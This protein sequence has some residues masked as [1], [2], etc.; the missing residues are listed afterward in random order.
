L[1][2]WIRVGSDSPS[3]DCGNDFRAAP[4]EGGEVHAHAQKDAGNRE[5]VMADTDKAEKIFAGEQILHAERFFGCAIPGYTALEGN[6][7]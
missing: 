5:R 2:L 4:Q 7:E 1:V 6:D 3:G